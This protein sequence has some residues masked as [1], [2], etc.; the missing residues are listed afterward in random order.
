MSSN[1]PR[2]RLRLQYKPTLWFFCLSSV[3]VFLRLAYTCYR[4]RHWIKLKRSRTSPFLGERRLESWTRLTENSS[5]DLVVSSLRN[6]GYG[7]CIGFISGPSC[8]LASP[9]RFQRKPMWLSGSL[10]CISRSFSDQAN[11]VV[12]LFV[13]N[14]RR[15]ECSFSCRIGIT[16]SCWEWTAVPGLECFLKQTLWLHKII[17][18]EWKRLVI[19]LT[20]F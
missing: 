2:A 20:N 4:K 16:F 3:C 5:A 13:L 19:R 15:R 14:L 18:C 9:D 12:W 6:T 10:Y 1:Q 8:P 17:W 11:V 7:I